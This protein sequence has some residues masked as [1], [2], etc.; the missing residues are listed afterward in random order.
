MNSASKK[1]RIGVLPD[2]N[3]DLD[4]SEDNKVS[5]YIIEEKRET[6]KQ[7]MNLSGLQCNKQ[8]YVCG[9]Y[10]GVD[11]KRSPKLNQ[12]PICE[13][14][15]II[16]YSPDKCL[17]LKWSRFQGENVVIFTAGG[18]L[19]AMDVDTNTQKRFFFGHSAPV[20][21]FDLNAN[22]A[23]LASAQEGKH[24]IIRLWEYESGRCISMMTMPV[25]TLK[26]VAFSWDGKYLASVGKDAHNK[27]MLIVW[28]I[29]RVGQAKPEIVAKQTSDFNILGLKF[30][31]IDSSRMVSCGKENIRF[32][33][34][35][36]TG[37]IRGSAVVLNHHARNSVFPSLDF[38]YS[39]HSANAKE[40]ES[41]NRVFVGSKHGMVFQINYQSESLEATYQ[42]NDSAIFAIAVNEAFCV[43]GSEDTYLRVWPLDFSEFFMEAKHEGTVCAVDISPDGLKVVCGTLY[44]SLGVLDKSN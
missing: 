4:S 34:I 1:S 10:I 20:C 42:T 43:T 9:Q 41:L 5:G 24:S 3:A 23:L 44:G 28:D 7:I 33:R 25:T 32:W 30:S 21:C 8:D 36:D 16:G 31:P 12:D 22:G 26:C 39:L 29:T 17:N 6:R 40:K 18:T 13:L 38:D 35:K 27:E 14:K 2:L 37:S 15:H 19:I 11:L